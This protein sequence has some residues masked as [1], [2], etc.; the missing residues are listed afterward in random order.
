MASSGRLISRHA[1]IS[2][3][4]T[5][6]DLPRPS[7]SAENKMFKETFHNKSKLYL[8]FFIYKQNKKTTKNPTLATGINWVP[9]QQ[10]MTGS[11]KVVKERI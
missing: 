3:E 6:P 5:V 4:I 1:H 10:V 8:C 7:F 11:I 9:L 2:A